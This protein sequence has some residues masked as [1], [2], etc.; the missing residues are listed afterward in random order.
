MELREEETNKLNRIQFGAAGVGIVGAILCALGAFLDAPQ[1]FYSYLMAVLFWLGISLGCLIWLLVHFLAGGR[2]SVMIRR[3]LEA[4]TML[5]LPMALLFVPI[6][7]GLGD[8]YLWSHA[9][10]VAEDPILQHKA[11][12]LNVTFFTARTV[13]YF[14]LWIGLALLLRYWSVREDNADAFE[15]PEIWRRLRVLS[16]PGFLL[17]GLTITF[18]SVDWIM[19][20]EPHWYSTIFGALLATN[21]AAMAISFAII[22]LS[23]LAGSLPFTRILNE[24]HISNLANLLLTSVILA[25]YMAF[26]QY[27]VIWSGNLPEEVVW[28]LHRLRGGWQ[29]IPVFLLVFHLAIPFAM[30][31]TRRA[32][33]EIRRLA[34]VAALVLFAN[35]V[36]LFW[37]IAPALH[38]GIFFVHWL[39]IVAPLAVGGIWIALFL[40][41]LQ[42]VPIMPRHDP[43]LKE[44][45]PHGWDEAPV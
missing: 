13:L 21:Q 2:W 17:Y 19:S 40:W 23:F 14:A 11:P 7:F 43:V 41:V 30:L 18:A 38:E 15:Q 28:Y 20:L 24:T 8:L 44:A 27:L 16:G 10:I 42:R 3:L 39:D 5:V 4:G 12:Y 33:Q 29:W 26:I 9:E 22:T 34:W 35:L 45:H 31:L 6:F 37:L 36:H 1:F 32:K 25:S